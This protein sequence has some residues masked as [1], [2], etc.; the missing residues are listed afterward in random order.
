MLNVQH[1]EISFYVIAHA[2]DFQLFMQPN[3]FN[4]LVADNSKV[5]FIVT[6]AGDA[7]MGE[8]YW[9]AREEGL[10][11]S[12]RFCLASFVSLSES[13]VIKKLNDHSINYWS[14][15]NA[16][17]YFLRLP[18]GGLDGNGF[19]TN[20]NKSLQKLKTG[21]I[22]IVDAIDNSTTYNGWADFYKTLESIILLEGKEASGS[23]INYLNPDTT[24]NINDHPDHIATGQAVQSMD[25]TRNLH[26]ALFLGYSVRDCSDYLCPPDLFWK[27]GML[28]AYEK[29]VFDRSGYSTFRENIG[30]YRE[31]CLRKASF[32]TFTYNCKKHE[33][34][35]KSFLSNLRTRVANLRKVGNPFEKNSNRVTIE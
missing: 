23:R 30:L 1:P 12:V 32:T 16:G 6:T 11:S 21:E 35:H 20:N 29:A 31:W 13:S 34:W 9:M 2:D 25:V 15:N 3:A 27:A 24:V 19:S 17:C 10:K 7:G 18:D 26:Q 22:S 8:T 33:P 5:V 28:G 14:A 4:D